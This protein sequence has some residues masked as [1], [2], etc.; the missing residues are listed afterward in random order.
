MAQGNGE[1]PEG[2]TL[3]GGIGSFFRGVVDAVAPVRALNR[4]MMQYMELFTN[5][6]VALAEALQ[7]FMPNNKTPAMD[8]VQ[9]LQMTVKIASMLATEGVEKMRDCVVKCG[10]PLGAETVFSVMDFVEQGRKL[11]NIVDG[12]I[13]FGGEFGGGEHQ[14]VRDAND[15]WKAEQAIVRHLYD[16]LMELSGGSIR[17]LADQ[18][19]WSDRLVDTVEMVGRSRPVPVE[20]GR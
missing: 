13:T 18:K 6:S 12:S 17:S 20:Y 11:R 2:V 3:E 4:E 14:R 9:N 8:D 1:K 7:P 10:T 16:D 19:G 15:F 5:E